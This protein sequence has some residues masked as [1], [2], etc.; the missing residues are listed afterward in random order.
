MAHLIVLL[1]SYLPGVDPVATERKE[2]H[3]TRTGGFGL[4]R[5]ALCRPG[6]GA[7][8]QGCPIVCRS[9]I[10]DVNDCAMDFG[11]N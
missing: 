5:G 10:L 3:R 8:N 4:H 2:I 11:S 7:A 9:F 6:L 1:A